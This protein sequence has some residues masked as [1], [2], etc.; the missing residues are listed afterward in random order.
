VDIPQ[1]STL[2]NELI[3]A[4]DPK[5]KSEA[6][7]LVL[8]DPMTSVVDKVPSDPRGLPGQTPATSRVQTP[9]LLQW[10]ISA[11]LCI[12]SDFGFQLLAL[13]P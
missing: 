9:V 3:K 12:F 11:L 1:A 5:I 2:L 8:S 10:I 6:Q 4:W 7:L 13:F